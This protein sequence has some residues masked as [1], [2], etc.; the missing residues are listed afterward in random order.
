MTILD[1]AWPFLVSMKRERDV[2]EWPRTCGG[3]V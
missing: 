1:I 2:K 3:E